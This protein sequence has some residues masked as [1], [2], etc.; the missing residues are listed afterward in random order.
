MAQVQDRFQNVST[1]L[2]A[3]F[4][5]IFPQVRLAYMLQPAIIDRC[6][7]RLA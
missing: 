6:S 1:P 4:V 5:D 3:G 7:L 2:A